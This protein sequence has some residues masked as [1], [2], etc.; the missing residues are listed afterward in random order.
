[1]PNNYTITHVPVEVL[2]NTMWTGQ[3][4]PEFNYTSGGLEGGS[5]SASVGD[6]VEDN[7][8][9]PL[10]LRIDPISDDYTVCVKDFTIGGQDFS[11]GGVLDTISSTETVTVRVL[12]HEWELGEDQLSYDEPI[13]FIDDR[14]KKIVLRDRDSSGT[15][16]CLVTEQEYGNQGNCVFVLVYLKNDFVTGQTNIQIPIDID[17]DATYLGDILD[18]SEPTISF[19]ISLTVKPPSVNSLNSTS[20]QNTMWVNWLTNP[21]YIED[22]LVNNPNHIN[23]FVWTSM[24]GDVTADTGLTSQS[25]FGGD[26]MY[27]NYYRLQSDGTGAYAGSNVIRATRGDS[28]VG[29]PGASPIMGDLN[30]EAVPYGRNKYWI[31]E[32]KPKPGYVVSRHMFNIRCK[33]DKFDNEPF[34][35]ESTVENEFVEYP[36]KWTAKKYG[37][38]G[39][40]YKSS[41]TPEQDN[42]E[43]IQPYLDQIEGANNAELG[44]H[45]PVH[46]ALYPATYFYKPYIGQWI[47]NPEYDFSN[48]SN[49]GTA[50]FPPST[51]G[52][53]FLN[54]GTNQVDNPRAYETELGSLIHTTSGEGYA[55]WG[56]C[57]WYY[58]DPEAMFQGYSNYNHSN[59]DNYPPPISYFETQLQYKMAIENSI[60]LVDTGWSTTRD[61][62]N[63]ANINLT[64]DIASELGIDEP[65]GLNV[66]EGGVWDSLDPYP[67]YSG[68]QTYDGS[69][70]GMWEPT[71]VENEGDVSWSQA[72]T[73][74]GGNMRWPDP[75]RQFFSDTVANMNAL[76][77]WSS[78]GYH[79]FDY[80]WSDMNLVNS[81]NSDLNSNVNWSI[82]RRLS[83]TGGTPPPVYRHGFDWI[84]YSSALAV[85]LYFD[86]SLANFNVVRGVYNHSWGQYFT[87][88]D[89]TSNAITN[90]LEDGDIDFGDYNYTP[91]SFKDFYTWNNIKAFCGKIPDYVTADD[92][93]NNTVLV[94]VPNF[95]NWIPPE[96]ILHLG[97]EIVG[98]AIPIDIL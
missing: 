77:L 52:G 58:Y 66:P 28:S 23:S 20:I 70:S 25:N 35:A 83:T 75:P 39:K 47:R 8:N 73:N 72:A 62:V 67:I 53:A 82:F 26:N 2:P 48:N 13:S 63:Q 57:S 64:D 1:M 6:G 69:D 31:W 24:V 40:K 61:E 29:S 36:G 3:D 12:W 97:F 27:N 19:G 51:G 17:G 84:N 88:M 95:G 65:V 96:D 32:I 94:I 81:T 11:A 14:V 89:S 41:A 87:V 43:A 78:E 22:T 54:A 91:E 46:G 60:I 18:C 98:E 42:I 55:Q 7:G 86:E 79:L 10:V 30:G 44:L 33:D 56:D 15:R 80:S 71:G 74:D 93:A 4:V 9:L 38:W 5:I 37:W 76:N 92:L 21:S 85:Q 68:W 49:P 90:G 59:E 45:Y 34:Q 16:K 50:V